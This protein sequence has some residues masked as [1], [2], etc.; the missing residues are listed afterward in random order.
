MPRRQYVV[1]FLP[2]S[3]SS[4]ADDALVSERWRRSPAARTGKIGDGRYSF[5]TWRKWSYPTGERGAEAL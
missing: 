2:R 3:G 5:F 1:D 4:G